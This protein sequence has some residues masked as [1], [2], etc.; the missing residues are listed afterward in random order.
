MMTDDREDDLRPFAS[1]PCLMHELDETFLGLAR[2]PVPRSASGRLLPDRSLPAYAYLPGRFPHPIRDPRGHSHGS[3]GTE[4]ADPDAFLW[5]M[6]LFDQGFYWEAHEAWEALWRAA[7]RGSAEHS[8]LQGLILLAAAGVKLREGK[9]TA[10]RRHGFRAAS[11]LRRAAEA[12]A[13]ELDP[14]LRVSPACL[15]VQAEAAVT[16]VVADRT[17][18]SFDFELGRSRTP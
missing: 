10:A 7:Q 5:G 15:A 2:A 4:S 3:A 13:G 17:P 9:S 8:L 1:P 6:D 11:F 12:S 16:R 14:R 18:L